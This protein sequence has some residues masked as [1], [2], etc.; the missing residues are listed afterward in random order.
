MLVL[1]EVSRYR[2]PSSSASSCPC[3]SVMT[4][5]NA[6]QTPR[7]LPMLV[8]S[9]PPLSP[10]A[11]LLVRPVALVADEDLV[12]ALGSVLL[13]VCVPGS[14]VC[15]AGEEGEHISISSCSG[16]LS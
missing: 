6:E 9:D 5:T 1:A 15:H 3:C 7:Q 4:W 14:D 13:Y 12:D 10:V 11:H 16:G 8:P 2:S